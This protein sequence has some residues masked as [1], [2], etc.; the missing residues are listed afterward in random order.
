MKKFILLFLV[1]INLCSFAQTVKIP[2]SNKIGE[3]GIGNLYRPAWKVTGISE[4]KGYDTTRYEKWAIAEIKFNTMQAY[5]E[6]MI[7]KK[8][9]KATYEYFLKND[10]AI[11]TSYLYKN[12]ISRNLIGVFIGL[13]DHLKYVIV[14]KN[15]NKNFNDDSI[16]VFDLDKKKIYPETE[17]YIDYFDG[18]QIRQ[19]QIPFTVDAYNE[20][21]SI[22]DAL[23]PTIAFVDRS[24]KQG[25]YNDGHSKWTI[26]VDNPH[27]F[28]YKNEM[29]SLCIDPAGKPESVNDRYI[30]SRRDSI[31]I[32]KK[33]YTVKSLIND[34]LCLSYIAPY[35]ESMGQTNTTA[36]E[37]TGKDLLTN[38]KISLNKK[39][40]QYVLLDFWG[41]WCK[42]CIAALPKLLEIHN[43]YKRSGLQVVSVAFDHKKDL[44]KVKMLINEHNLMWEH[45]FVDRAGAQ[46]ITK[47]YRVQIYP[48]TI[49]INPNGKVVFRGTGEKSLIEIDKFL[50]KAI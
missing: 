9:P 14:D 49:L 27:F 34:T 5:L 29:F 21:S 8:I 24:Y 11:D 22:D 6:D 2:L 47:N 4:Y 19:A 48:T 40:G 16:L 25:I 44:D 13:K 37:I 15:G 46:E 39:R 50:K 45:L 38:K 35:L 36:P 26:T 30:H 33:L 42:P 23:K 17:V 18:E 32:G 31:P 43:K 41:S 10:H 7:N 1:L 12:T 20:G 3:Y 28:L